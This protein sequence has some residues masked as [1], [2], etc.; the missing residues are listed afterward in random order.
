MKIKNEVI[1]SIIILLVDTFVLKLATF[2]FKGIYIE[3]FW[4]GFLAALLIAILNKLLK[5]FLKLLTLPITVLSLGL[6]YPLTDVIILKLVSFL[7]GDEF[8]IKGLIAPFF[9]AIFISITTLILE[10][11]VVNTFKEGSK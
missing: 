8:V 7:I 9:I 1:M 3:S 6:L 5:L 2:I 11:I 4:Y 10:R